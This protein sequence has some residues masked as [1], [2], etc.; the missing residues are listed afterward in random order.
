MANL[1][2]LL[3]DAMS[4]PYANPKLCS[5]IAVCPFYQQKKG[6]DVCILVHADFPINV[7]KK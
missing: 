2:N 1:A 6:S 5:L 3:K 7:L 4:L